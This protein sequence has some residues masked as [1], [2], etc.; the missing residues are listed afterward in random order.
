ME[1][2]KGYLH[3]TGS[4]SGA[5]TAARAHPLHQ[6]GDFLTKNGRGRC[7]N[8]PLQSR[9]RAPLCEPDRK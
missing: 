6:S 1:S 7:G 5:P 8:G 2:R 3:K 4:R 9:T